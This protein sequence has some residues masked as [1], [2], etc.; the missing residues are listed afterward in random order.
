MS[1]ISGI[2]TGF[3][4]SVFITHTRCSAGSQILFL[5]K[6]SETCQKNFHL[7]QT[8]SSCEKRE[9]LTS[10][11]SVHMSLICV[12]F[13]WYF[14]R[15]RIS[16]FLTQQKVLCGI[17]DIFL[18]QTIWDLSKIFQLQQTLS[19]YE[20][21]WKLKKHIFDSYI[22]HF[23]R[24]TAT[25]SC[26]YGYQ[27]FGSSR[28]CSAGSKK[29]FLDKQ[30]ETCQK[31]FHLR[32][33]HSSYK[34]TWKSKNLT[35]YCISPILWYLMIFSDDFMGIGVLDSSRRCSAGSKKIFLD[36]QSETCQK[37]FELQQLLSSY[38]ET[39]KSQNCHI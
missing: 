15:F 8:H 11:K 34:E 3:S 37:S 5:D 12:I 22:Y 25:F 14:R 28:R 35:F 1:L 9:N 4:V 38:E 2:F 6:Q 13:W 20:V 24:S 18:R 27:C 23:I 19:S 21:I 32:Q 39:W 33:T 29:I 17:Q 10:H 30:S 26:F 16:V 31:K 7:R 36:K